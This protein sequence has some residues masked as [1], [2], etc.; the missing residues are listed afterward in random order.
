MQP[1]PFIKKQVEREAL[2]FTL[3]LPNK[4]TW[5]VMNVLVFLLICWQILGMRH[6]LVQKGKKQL[7]FFSLHNFHLLASVNVFLILGIYISGPKLYVKPSAKSNK[8]IIHN[9]ISH[10][11]LAGSVNTTMK[12]KVLEVSLALMVKW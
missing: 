12:N 8:S 3:Y 4:V 6:F 9:A 2:Y 7:L 11:C 5:K 1:F 10:C